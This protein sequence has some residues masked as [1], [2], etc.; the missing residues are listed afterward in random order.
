MK[1]KASV[2]GVIYIPK[3][4]GFKL[5]IKQMQTVVVS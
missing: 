1:V 3:E 2:P 4:K 5:D